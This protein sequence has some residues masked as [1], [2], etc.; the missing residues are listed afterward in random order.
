M[1]DHLNSGPSAP[2]NATNSVP[3]SSYHNT[4]P[5][6]AINNDRPS[7]RLKTS[8]S[9]DNLMNFIN[10]LSDELST[11]N[12]INNVNIANS[13]NLTATSNINSSQT[14][15]TMTSNSSSLTHLLQKPINSNQPN[16]QRTML[17]NANS[18]ISI[19]QLNMPSQPRNSPQP[20]RY[21][22]QSVQQSQI[23]A[24][25]VQ[26]QMQQQ[27]Q[28]QQQQ[29]MQQNFQ[30]NPS[31]RMP[32]QQ[33]PQ[34]FR[35]ISPNSN[36]SNISI[37][38]LSQGSQM[39]SVFSNTGQQNHVRYPNAQVNHGSNIFDRSNADNEKRKLIQQQLVLLLHAHKCQKREQNHRQNGTE[40][41]KQCNLPH[42]P[43][44]KN[45]LSH[46]SV[47]QAG[48]NFAQPFSFLI[49]ILT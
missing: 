48:K 36:Q 17:S 37:S 46:M 13:S 49:L 11:N 45:V 27:Q 24:P 32:Q 44:M 10:D 35:F 25:H 14:A 31:Q 20:H 34:Q 12:V 43:T 22:A 38:Q 21:S 47:C 2:N 28:Q 15:D 19:Q 33:Q 5:G 3:H 8:D 6:A 9:N 4:V 39:T 42:C 26:I 18:N 1:G 23:N 41:P 40:Q 16:M 29:F 7:K 30:N